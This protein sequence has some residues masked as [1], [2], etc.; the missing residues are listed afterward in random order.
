MG[1][2]ALFCQITLTSVSTLWVIFRDV[3][4]WVWR[5]STVLSGDSIFTV[6]VLRIHCFGL[7]HC[8]H[9]GLALTVLILCL[10][11]KTSRHMT[12]EETRHSGL[13]VITS[14]LMCSSFFYLICLHS[15]WSY[16]VLA[17]DRKWMKRIRD[18]ILDTAKMNLIL[19]MVKTWKKY[20]L[21]WW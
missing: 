14:W 15:C 20:E 3:I 19:A 16:A 13:I 1:R 5:H 18:I 17:A 7:D 12:T 9:V 10:E 6:S 21:K 4:M 8:L 11:T 2:E